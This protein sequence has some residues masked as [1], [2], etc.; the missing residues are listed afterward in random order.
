[1]KSERI[2]GTTEETIRKA[3]MELAFN[4][5]PSFRSWLL[6]NNSKGIEEI[7]IFPV[8]D[9]RNPRKTWDS[10][11]RNYKENWVTIFDGNIDEVKNILPFGE[12]GTGDY[13]CFERNEGGNNE[14]P[15]VLWLH[16]TGEFEFLAD[17]FDGLVI[18][19]KSGDLN[20]KQAG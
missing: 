4:F 18:K 17:S 6:E 19:L 5:P 8:Y 12:F 13:L 7:T 10:I 20:F 2:V 3:E 11:V 1:M 15:V 9:E 16:E 14:L